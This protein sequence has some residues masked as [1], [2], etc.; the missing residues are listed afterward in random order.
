MRRALAALAGVWLALAAGAARAQRPDVAR[1]PYASDGP[2]QYGELRLPPGPGPFPLAIVIH[3]GCW[4]AD[5]ATLDYVAPLADALRREGVATWNVEYR[6][7]GDDG[8]GWPGTF[9]DVAA[10]TDFARTLAKDQPIDLA[11]VVV[12]GHSAGAHLALW[13]A[14]RG[15]LMANSELHR[16]APLPLRGVIALGGPGDLR[17][18]AKRADEF[19]GNGVL[20]H[21]LGGTEVEVPQ[22]YLEASPAAFLPLGVRQVIVAGGDDRIMPPRNAEPYARAARKAGD[23]A[24]LVEL[25]GANHFDLVSP[26]SRTWPTVKA[27]VIELLG[28]MIAK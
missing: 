12:I 6:R 22:H 28:G 3:G 2:L 8:G 27:K 11:R 1:I 24:E 19:C 20:E 25:S 26:T 9:K 4:R 23:T 21:L 5:T 15:K 14:A 10:A 16:A 17:G 13:D 18:L 7:V